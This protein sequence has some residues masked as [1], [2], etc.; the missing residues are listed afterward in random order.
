M[1]GQHVILTDIILRLCIKLGPTNERKPDI[2]LSE[3]ELICLL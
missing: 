1:T 2:C 3:T